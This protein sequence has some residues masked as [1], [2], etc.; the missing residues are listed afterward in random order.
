MCS[1]EIPLAGGNVNAGVVR[2][3]D[4]VRR[5]MSAVSPTV[6]RLLKHLEDKGFDGAPRFLGIDDQ[7]REILSF[8][9]GESGIPSYLWEGDGP[10]IAAAQLLRRYHEA[11]LDFPNDGSFTWGI[12]YR[13]ASRH[14]VICHNDFA[15]YNFIYR[16]QKP[17]AVIDF[18]L[19]GPGPRL[20]DIAYATYWLTPLSFGSDDL[21]TWSEKDLQ[22]GSRRLHLFCNT[23]GVD[24]DRALLEM[25]HEVLSFMGNTMEMLPLLGPEVTSKLEADGH[26]THWQKEA[27]AFLDNR[28]RL[29]I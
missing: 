20:R 23:Y 14:E 13:D 25:V 29:S 24:V 2:L 22:N 18:D 9:E 8:V 19:I 21:R 6:H 26:V 16:D 12:A 27:Q 4:T 15:P 17:V 3:G 5:S 28:H 10:L 7:E 11:T 1:E